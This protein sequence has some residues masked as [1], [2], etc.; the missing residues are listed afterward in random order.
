MSKIKHYLPSNV[1]WTI[2]NTL[3][4]PYINYGLLTWGGKAGSLLR[5]QKRAVRIITK[6]HFRSHTN[7]LFQS[8]NLLK[9]H[10]LCTLQ[11][12]KFCYKFENYSLPQYFLVDMKKPE[13]N[14]HGYNTRNAMKMKLPALKHDFAKHSILI[15]IH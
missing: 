1:L 13:I 5:L 8:L 10:D 11:D 4:L 3:I 6:S 12:Y 9:I 7:R 14:N 15:N 2:Y